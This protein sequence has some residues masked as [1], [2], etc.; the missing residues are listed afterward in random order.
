MAADVYLLIED[1]IVVFA[2]VHPSFQ[3]QQASLFSC[4]IPATNVVY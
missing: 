1:L 2:D 3:T 4:T